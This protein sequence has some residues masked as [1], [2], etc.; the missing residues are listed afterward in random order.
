MKRDDDKIIISV[1]IP[2]EFYDY[3]KKKA[4][5]E[6]TSVS[7]LIRKMIIK[8]VNSHKEENING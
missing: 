8:D 3:L 5:E 2:N 1:Q 6:C 7:Y 4:Q